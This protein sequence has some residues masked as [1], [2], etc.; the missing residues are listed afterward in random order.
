MSRCSRS[1]ICALVCGD[2]QTLES[3]S[4]YDIAQIYAATNRH[5]GVAALVSSADTAGVSEDELFARFNSIVD[6]P[7][8]VLFISGTVGDILTPRS[9]RMNRLLRE[10][11][12]SYKPFVVLFDEEVTTRFERVWR[13]V[14]LPSSMGMCPVDR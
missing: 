13:L 5:I 10:H 1:S 4:S 11:N 6:F 8:T 14:N 3:I 12:V 2:G 7:L 9:R